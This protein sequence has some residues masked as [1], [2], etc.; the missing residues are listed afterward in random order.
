MDL[1]PDRSKYSEGGRGGGYSSSSSD[2]QL[3]LSKLRGAIQN[4][5]LK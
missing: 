3:V 2:N 4:N 5:I 1:G